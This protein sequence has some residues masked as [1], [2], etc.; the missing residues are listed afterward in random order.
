MATRKTTTKA[1][2]KTTKKPATKKTSA[3]KTTTVSKNQKPTLARL[4]QLNLVSGVLALLLALVAG[5]LMGGTSYQ[6]F[7]SLLTTDELAS[8]S[9]TVFVPAV[10]FVVDVQ[11]RWMV[12]AILVLA[13]IIPLLAATRNRK[14]Y[15]DSLAKKVMP[16]R[17]IEMGVL[18]ALMVEVIALLSGIQD[19]LTL[20]LMAGFMVVTGLLGWFSEKQPAANKSW[21]YYYLSLA[22][23]VLPWLVIAAAAVGTVVYGGVRSPWYVYALYASTLLAFGAYATNGKRLLNGRQNY[24]TS[25][26]MNLQIGLLAKVAF[27]VI[28]IVGL[29]K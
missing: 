12:V 26:L 17:W 20:K 9:E 19:I 29:Y 18:S 13:S 2:T 11:L 21:R 10:H 4:K 7:T 27:A 25:E 22:T 3:A 1:K 24:E 15:E 23:G 8:T 14:M 6:L 16:W 28:L 5:L